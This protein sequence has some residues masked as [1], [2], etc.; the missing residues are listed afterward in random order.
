[1]FTAGSNAFPSAT[2]PLNTV[3][4]ATSAS[5]V[6]AADGMVGLLNM[7]A[8]G[9]LCNSSYDNFHFEL[10]H[11]TNS[12]CFIDDFIS[13]LLSHSAVKLL[14]DFIYSKRFVLMQETCCQHLKIWLESYTSCS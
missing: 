3:G 1:M 6:A 14:W 8:S 5:T 4:L 13:R 11:R 9:N 12:T 10:M 2:T 7:R